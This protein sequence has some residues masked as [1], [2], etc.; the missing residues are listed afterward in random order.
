MSKIILNNVSEIKN[1]E[2]KIMEPKE[3]ISVIIVRKG[4][5]LY[6]FLNKCPHQSR[7]MGRVEVCSENEIRC[8]HH[9]MKF[10]FITGENTFSSGYMGIPSLQMLKIYDEN[11]QYFI[12]LE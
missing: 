12:E 11:G 1:G 10:N 7:E 8:E 6:A 9:G 5:K 2:S 3:G 4:E